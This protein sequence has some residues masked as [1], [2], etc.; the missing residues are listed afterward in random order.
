MELVIEYEWTFTDEVT[1][2]TWDVTFRIDAT[3]TLDVPAQTSGPPDSWSPAEP[4]GIEIDAITACCWSPHAV[5]QY[6]TNQF[7]TQLE[8]DVKLRASVQSLLEEELA[9][10]LTPPED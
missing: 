7:K 6:L 3:A 2:C 9:R 1:V 10:C 4:G 5:P 8:T